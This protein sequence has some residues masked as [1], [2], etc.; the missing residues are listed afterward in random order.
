MVL[1]FVLAF[2]DEFDFAKC[3]FDWFQGIWIIISIHGSM[4]FPNKY[5]LTYFNVTPITGAN[6]TVIWKKKVS[7]KNWTEKFLN[8]PR[9]T[10]LR[11]GPDNEREQ[12][13][14]FTLIKSMHVYFANH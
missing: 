13:I 1:E 10:V 2:L 12:Y 8:Y 11:D 6:F 3:N 4:N 5:I 14:F 9:K 7:P